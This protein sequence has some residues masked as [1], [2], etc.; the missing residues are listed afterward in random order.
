LNSAKLNDWMQVVG[1]FAL[2]ASLVFVGLQIKQAQEIAESETY[3]ERAAISVEFSA[4]RA[5]SPQFTS[6]IA[7]IYAG[8]TEDLTVQ[9]QVTLEY[10][11]GG[12]MTI[13]ENLHYQY[14]SGYL[15]EEH[16]QK[17]L[18]EMRC[19]L[20][21]PYYREVVKYL[22]FRTTFQAIIDEILAEVRV[23]PSNCWE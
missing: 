9:E 10:F 13:Y 22:E 2:V 19:E 6:A 12:Q 23:N 5:S 11:F 16:W 3:L 18:A 20:S 21:L 15:A 1:I 8:R 7:K 17:D 14:L 4:M